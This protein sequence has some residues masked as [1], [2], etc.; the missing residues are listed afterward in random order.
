M[1]VA[2]TSSTNTLVRTRTTY[3][4]W[5]ERVLR[6]PLRTEISCHALPPPRCSRSRR[7]RPAR[8]SEFFGGAGGG[9]H[10]V[11]FSDVAAAL[12]GEPVDNAAIVRELACARTGR[13]SPAAGCWPGRG[14]DAG[15]AAKPARR[16]LR[17]RHLRRCW[18]GAMFAILLGLS[19]AGLNFL[20]FAGA[21]SAM[22]DRFG[23]ATATAR[24]RRRAC[25]SPASSSPRA[26][27]HWS[28]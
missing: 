14:A 4:Y 8:R 11:P 2:T 13:P 22:P 27:A 5:R 19:A 17:A 24:G 23:L 16:P 18:V 21:L 1:P 15:A 26:A 9:Q 10:A 7:A 6:Y 20:A 12:L 25:C 3:G 28:R